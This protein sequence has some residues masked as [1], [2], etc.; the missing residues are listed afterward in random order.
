VAVQIA[1]SAEVWLR[2]RVLGTLVLLSSSA[3][4]AELTPSRA[5]G[6]LE[7]ATVYASASAGTHLNRIGLNVNTQLRLDCVP[8]EASGWTLAL[9]P[10]VGLSFNATY[11][12]IPV[13]S[14]S[15]EGQ[16]RFV[17]AFG[18]ENYGRTRPDL[19]PPLR[20]HTLSYYLSWYATTDRT[21]QFSGGVSYT[22]AW[23]ANAI[24]VILENDVLAWQRRDEYRTGA[25]ALRYRVNSSG[26]SLGVGSTLLLWTGTTAGLGF[27][28]RGEVYDL[29][30]Q[31]GGAYSHGLISLD[32]L[33]DAWRV[34]VG[35][36][37]DRI[38]SAV[39][40]KL[41]DLID[42]GR[43]AN[44]DRANRIF[45]QLGLLDLRHLY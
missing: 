8:C 19:A 35:Y 23:G 34:S 33:Y 38:R 41:H 14:L 28:K 2:F 16:L 25:V 32:F 20:T 7:A 30:G 13:S 39:Q 27:L 9:R 4:G 36:D 43:I 17:A 18:R 31:R 10:D 26:R 40:D 21:N 37:S 24:D 3:F 12:G 5:Q 1:V 44:V 22:A 11:W 42:D 29:S 6:S 45:I 15:G